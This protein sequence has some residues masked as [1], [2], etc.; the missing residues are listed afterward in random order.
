MSE[1]WT[2]CCLCS[3]SSGRQLQAA[4]GPPC[5]YAHATLP[6]QSV[7][8]AASHPNQNVLEEILNTAFHLAHCRPYG[9]PYGPPPPFPGRP[10]YPGGPMGPPYGPPFGP[11]HPGMGPPGPG[12]TALAVPSAMSMLTSATWLA[13]TH[14]LLLSC[15]CT[16]VSHS[17]GIHLCIVMH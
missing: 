16:E 1:L 14:T 12:R 4:W 6:M 15:M 5:A 17:P 2:Y 9:G 7:A 11:P 10:P 13:G 8:L 3:H